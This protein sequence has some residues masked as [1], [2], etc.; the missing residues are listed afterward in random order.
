MRIA[1]LS[2][3]W[4]GARMGGI[5][6]YVRNAVAALAQGGHDVHVFTFALPPDTRANVPVGVT[7][8]EV[9]DLATRVTQGHLPAVLAAAIN[10]GGEA[11]Y[12]L[13]IA[14]LLTEAFKAQHAAQPFDVVEV[15]EVEALGLPL[16]V[17]ANIHVPVVTH[18]HCA[19]AIAYTGNAVAVGRAERLIAD[20][21][22]AA[23]H[24]ADAICAPTKKVVELTGAHMNRPIAADIIPHAFVANDL[25]FAA[26]DP[27]GP[28]LFVGRLERLKGCEV[29]A[30]AL[31]DFLND[32]PTATFR[33]L[34]PDTNTGPNGGSMQQF[35]ETTIGP[36]LQSRV[37][38]AGEVSRDAIDLE[39]AGA[40]FCVM[41]SLWENFS[42]AICEA[43]AAGRAVVVAGGSGS[44]EVV[45]DGAP[46]AHRGSPADLARWMT[47]LWRDRGTLEGHS[48]AAYRRV[49]QLCD[50]VRVTQQRVAWYTDA[51][52]RF[53]AAGPSERTARLATL[54]ASIAASVLPSIVSLAGS[55]CGVRH[56]STETPGSRLL[57]IFTEEA[58]RSGGRAR[59]MLYAAGKHTTRLLSE[60]H[61]W[62]SAGHAV[63]GII[64][65]HPRYAAGGEHLGLP[66]QS[67]ACA[68]ATRRAGRTLPAIVLSTDTYEDQFWAQTAPLRELG[69]DVHRL[70]GQRKA[71]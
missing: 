31:R 69:V 27:D 44:V 47:H 57:R 46:V 65:D 45:G 70:Y 2:H 16:L 29:L 8:H 34:A 54:P 38:F 67:L 24:L 30:E 18:L 4:P 43:M 48:L 19:T 36:D 51:I 62:E 60:R 3:Q 63:V 6:S 26:P 1:F 40:S 35:I 39:L 52:G 55:L 53:A 21:E 9:A 33:F 71:S 66:V 10:A 25:P 7:L 22:F 41:P 64:D 59:L 15:P 49:R 23:I 13:A 5:G 50:P 37:T 56:A 32:N 12:R 14:Q 20:L 61:L 58:G 11:I 42:M 28:V 17:D 68:V